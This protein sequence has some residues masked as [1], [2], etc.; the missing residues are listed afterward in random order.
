MRVS[1]GRAAGCLGFSPLLA[2]A[3][4]LALV[5]CGGGGNCLEQGTCQCLDAGD[6]PE[7]LDCIDGRCGRLEPPPQPVR[8]FGEPC[9]ADSECQ[10]G[11][12]LPRGPGNGAVCTRSCAELPCPD[13]YQCKSDVRA[14]GGSELLCVQSI[15]PRLCSGCASDNQCNAIGDLCVL[16]GEQRVCLLDCA[17]DDCPPGYQ[18]RPVPVPG[19]QARQC[20]PAGGSCDC[21]AGNLGLVRSCTLS[22]EYGNCSG[23]Q[24]CLPAEPVPA[25]GPCDAPWPERET[26]NGL[27]DDCDGLTDD[28]DADIDT[29]ALPADPPYP[30]CRPEGAEACLGRWR[31]LPLSGGGYGFVCGGVDPGVELCNGRDD[32]CNGIVDDPFVDAQ[33]RYVHLEH[34]GGCGG[35]CRS[36]IDHLRRGPDGQVAA[37]AVTCQVRGDQ[38]VC[39]PLECQPGYYPYPEQQPVLCAPL[40]SPACQPCSQDDDCRVSSDVCA[41]LEG[42]PGSFCLQSCDAFAPYDGCSGGTGVQDCCPDGYLCSDYQGGRFCLPENGTCTCNP[43]RLGATRPCLL[44]GSGGEVCQGQQTCQAGAAGDPAWDQCQPAQVVVEVCDYLDNNCDGRVD[45]DFVDEQGD[46]S[47]DAHCGRCNNDCSAR[48]SRVHQ[49]AIGGCRRQDGEYQ[50][51]IVSCTRESWP[52]WGPCRSDDDCHGTGQYCSPATH[53]C[54]VDEAACADG[55]CGLACGGDA[56]CRQL[57]PG[58]YC[59]DGRCQVEIE[60]HDVNGLEVDGCECGARVGIT[61]DEPDIIPG[62]PR[63]GEVYLDENCDGIDGNAA[64]AL[65][66]DSSSSGGDGSRE[67]PLATIA[68]ALAA[69]DPARHDH[70]LVAA[71][72]YQEQV[73]LRPGVRLYGGYSDD[74]SRRDVV[75]NPSII[76]A[77]APAA[78]QPP[79]SVYAAGISGQS[80]VLA[81][82]AIYG[83]DVVARPAPGQPGKSSY[84]VYLADCSDSLVLANNFIVGGRGGAGADGRNGASGGSGEDGGPG[85]DSLECDSADCFGQQ[86]A[87]GAAG[88]NP[89]CGTARGHDGA[90]ARPYCHFSDC[91][92]DYRGGGIDGSGGSDSIYGSSPD[93]S[94][95]KYDCQV[96]S[97]LIPSNGQDAR[98][99]ADGAAG[100][101]GAGCS[102]SRGRVVDGL[103]QAGSGSAGQAGQ[104]GQGGGGGGA[105][106]AVINYNSSP[107]CSVGLPYGDLGA[108]GGGGGAGG[109]RG[110][111]GP[112][113][114]GGGGSFGVFLVF[115]TTP[116]AFPKV[117][118]N[119]ILRGF[120]GPGGHG[121]GGGQGGLGGQG[122]PGGQVLLPAWC[123]GT[124]GSG[125]RGGDG[126][127]GGGGGG[128]CG[129]VSYGLASNLVDDPQVP[130]FAGNQFLAPA[131]QETGGAGGAGGGSPAGSGYGGRPGARGDSGDWWIY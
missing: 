23:L 30:A 105:G 31:C 4:L 111:G 93:P 53:H 40:L 66:V 120:G 127:A 89:G 55:D 112:G 103:F 101:G 13:G 32:D 44:L 56:D 42:E 10:S 98:P 26:C 25:W 97:G 117:R 19:G 68:A 63:G 29:S 15:P 20:L 28:A 49:H 45:E 129:G 74:F 61:T 126:G 115:T 12:C 8:G 77:P 83:Y 59:R 52:A 88:G 9:L 1:A 51:R 33:G 130:F 64:R 73:V 39:V 58:Y 91:R 90:T 48:W 43:E 99:G 72:L 50:C 27:D 54:R 62:V 22:N 84:A 6:C 107:P 60:F 128:G 95:C 75:L 46:Y 110:Q 82:F 118:H 41:V 122:G 37:G 17:Q 100:S 96:S 67:Q 114:S 131:G 80:T 124:G 113:G 21:S 5:S 87:G 79:G 34:C 2:L 65:F 85:R 94:L 121:G 71:G 11:R 92:Q 108:S 14:D 69:F 38:P 16:L 70:I 86:Q 123:A 106:G 35:D 125:G 109:C 104:D 116:A 57:G 119:R 36:M 78:G 102:D 81:G 3:G 18:C 24:E 76:M 47:G 7:G